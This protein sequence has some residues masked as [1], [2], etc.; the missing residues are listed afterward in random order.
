MDTVLADET[1]PS[2]T[3]NSGSTSIVIQ[4][5]RSIPYGLAVFIVFHRAIEPTRND[6]RASQSCGLI[7]GLKSCFESLPKVGVRVPVNIDEQCLSLHALPSISAAS[8]SGL[9]PFLT[10]FMTRSKMS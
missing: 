10:A 9:A 4:F 1:Q 8:S 7:R 2:S 6:H 5:A 3:V